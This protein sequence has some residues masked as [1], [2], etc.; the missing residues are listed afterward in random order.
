M[1]TK[2]GMEY[3]AKPVGMGALLGTTAEDTMSES[4]VSAMRLREEKLKKAEADKENRNYMAL[5]GVPIS[6]VATS[7]KSFTA[8]Q[9]VVLSSYLVCTWVLL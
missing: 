3:L 6:S 5:L 8:L 1:I 4:N 2:P 9:Q 7:T